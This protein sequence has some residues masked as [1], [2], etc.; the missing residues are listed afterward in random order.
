[1]QTQD[2][3]HDCHASQ[4]ARPQRNGRPQK[5]RQPQRSSKPR[6]DSQELTSRLSSADSV[7]AVLDLVQGHHQQFNQQHATAALNKVACE[8]SATFF[9]EPISSCQRHAGWLLLLATVQRLIPRFDTS[10]LSSVVSA[11]GMLDIRPVWLPELLSAAEASMQTRPQD[12][13]LEDLCTCMDGLSHRAYDGDKKFLAAAEQLLP[14]LL[15]GATPKA[16]T[17]I[18]HNLALRLKVLDRDLL[19]LI[20]EH[21]LTVSPRAATGEVAGLLHGLAALGTAA[22]PSEQVL[23]DCAERLASTVGHATARSVRLPIWAFGRLQFCP[24]PDVMQALL[25]A[26]ALQVHAMTPGPCLYLTA[27]ASTESATLAGLSH[28]A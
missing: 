21:F 25:Q 22:A 13:T 26:N 19:D 3:H 12:W 20:C 24:S 27:T 16:V 1:M 7:Q 11:C 4:T 23:N 28:E 9:P 8:V 15:A 14:H 5:S 17:Y 2:W 6:P 18:V 10:Q